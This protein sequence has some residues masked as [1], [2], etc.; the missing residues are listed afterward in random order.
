[1]QS[2]MLQQVVSLD[3]CDLG[4]NA[5]VQAPITLLTLCTPLRRCIQLCSASHRT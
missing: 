1:M 5:Q 4:V 2:D 3:H